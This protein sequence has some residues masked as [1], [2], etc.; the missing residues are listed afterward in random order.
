[1]QP[2]RTVAI[3]KQDRYVAVFYEIQ[4]DNI[5]YHELYNKFMDVSQQV[6]ELGLE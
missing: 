2:I 4:K 1:M 6:M 5:D 3:G